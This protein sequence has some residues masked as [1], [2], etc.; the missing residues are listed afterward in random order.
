MINSDGN[1]EKTWNL[2]I[3]PSIR[4]IY[5]LR[6]FSINYQKLQEKEN[7]EMKCWSNEETD[8]MMRYKSKINILFENFVYELISKTLGFFF[9]E[10]SL[11]LGTNQAPV[12][13]KLKSLWVLLFL[14]DSCWIIYR[15][16]LLCLHLKIVLVI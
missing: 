4:D 2:S 15:M 5:E 13:G 16:N 10:K 8:V 3:S 7:L 9:G 1:M 14:S 12:L 11:Q 6:L